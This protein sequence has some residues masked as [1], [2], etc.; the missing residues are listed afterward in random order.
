MSSE[1]ASKSW[2]Y[3]GRAN[4]VKNKGMPDRKAFNKL[5]TRI[6]DFARMVDSTTSVD[7]YAGYHKP[8]SMQR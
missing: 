4:P 5:S 2:K 1:T 8:G 6:G 7:K 3:R